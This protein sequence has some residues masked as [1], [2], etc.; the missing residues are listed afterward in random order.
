MQPC[1]ESMDVQS[2]LPL[3]LVGALHEQVRLVTALGG[4]GG[5]DVKATV[6]KTS[7]CA[8]APSTAPPPA[9]P[10]HPTLTGHLPPGLVSTE[11]LEEPL[12]TDHCLLLRAALCG[13]ASSSSH[14]LGLTVA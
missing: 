6:T 5:G 4:G 14:S 10:T 3:A 1:L 8:L 2:L 11:V 13:K 12:H 7:I 9:R